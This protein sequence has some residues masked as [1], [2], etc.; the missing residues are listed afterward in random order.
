MKKIV[1]CICAA[2]MALSLSACSK[3]EPDTRP[4]GEMRGISAAEL[5][6][7]M[8]TGWNLG[9]TMDSEEGGETGWGNPVTTKEMIDEVHRAGFDTLRIPT[10]WKNSMGG[11]PDYTVDSEWLKRLEEIVGYA[12]ENDMYVII[13]THHDTD[14]IKPQYEDVENVKVQLAAL[15]TQIAEYFK[16]YGDHLIFEGLNEPRIVGGA[17]EWNGGTEE[18]RDCLNQLNDVFVKTVRAT[19]G[20]NETR[21]LLITTFAAQPAA[22]GVSALIVPDDKYVG[23]SI[24]AYTPYRFTYDSVGESWNTAVFDGSCASEID[25]LFAGLN[26]AFISKGI[27]V[28]ITEYGSVSKMIDKTWYITNTEEVAK[29]A[30]HYVSAAEK[31]GIPCVWW[32]NGYHKSGN[33]LF[34]IFNRRELT[35]YE[36]EVVTAIMESLNS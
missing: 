9:N 35:W 22:S 25:S 32:D 26:E 15:W 23:V 1:S 16:D 31:Y 29:W 21:T 17:N 20:N 8:G 11:A 24:H 14:W 7:E 12:L 33:E 13:N 2:A 4:L 19:G 36:P 18:G 3:K 5:I 27:P 34:G 10:T 28:I 6:A 30:K